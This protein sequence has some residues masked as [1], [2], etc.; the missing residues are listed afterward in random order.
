VLLVA[1]TAS[2]AWAGTHKS[3]RDLQPASGAAEV[4]ASAP[5]SSTGSCG[6]QRWAVKTG[7]DADA[8]KINLKA[9]TPTTVAALSALPAPRSLP[10]NARVQPTET[11]VFRVH[12]TLTKYLL[13]ADSDYYLVLSDRGHTMIAKI[14]DPV[15]V[16]ASSPLLAMIQRAR[17]QFDERLIA[18]FTFKSANVPVTVTGVGFF[19]SPRGQAGAAPNGIELHSVLDVHFGGNAGSTLAGTGGKGVCSGQLLGNPGFETGIAVP[20]TATTRVISNTNTATPHGG[21]WAAELLGYGT[22]HSDRLSQ[23]VTIPAGCQATLSLWLHVESSESGSDQPRDTLTVMMGSTTLATLS[24][25]DR[26][27][28]YIQRTYNVS[29]YAGQRLVLSFVGSEDA[30][31]KTSFVIDDASLLRS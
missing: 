24:N 22:V 4:V 25:L 26:G 9:V 21:S 5:K 12:A 2:A 20:W 31:G 10:V 14:T 7:T 17:A 8:G 11:T 15:C 28:G 29:R 16:G 13:G 6:V 3:R 1:V 18:T 30:G 19:D 27:R 23:V